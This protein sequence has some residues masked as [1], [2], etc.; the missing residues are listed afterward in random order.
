MLIT[1]VS[2]LVSALISAPVIVKAVQ[3]AN[4]KKQASREELENLSTGSNLLSTS[5][6]YEDPSTEMNPQNDLDSSSE[7]ITS[8]TENRSRRSLVQV[9]WGSD[10]N[11]YQKPMGATLSASLPES[12]GSVEKM[13]SPTRP[14]QSSPTPKIVDDVESVRSTPSAEQLFEDIK[15]LPPPTKVLNSPPP[16]AHSEIK[17]SSFETEKKENIL[18]NPSN[19][20]ASEIRK[21]YIDRHRHKVKQVSISQPRKDSLKMTIIDA[22]GAQTKDQHYEVIKAGLNPQK[23]DQSWRMQGQPEMTLDGE[24][25]WRSIEPLYID[26]SDFFSLDFLVSIDRTDLY[27]STPPQQGFFNSED[28]FDEDE[29]EWTGEVPEWQKLLSGTSFLYSLKLKQQ[30]QPN[31]IQLTH[32]STEDQIVY[33][34]VSRT[35]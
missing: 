33:D 32:Q 11:P 7:I 19:L 34:I 15:V 23:A 4:E 1:V 35:S 21:H 8:P 25:M 29:Q 24:Q 30:K 26:F 16:I 13:S 6:E 27:S 2:L 18:D 3:K 9:E 10:L 12:T 14:R 5:L 22:P 28:P 20:T 17:K 31:H